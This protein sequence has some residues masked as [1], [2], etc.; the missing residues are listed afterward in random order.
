MGSIYKPTYSR[1]L[2]DTADTFT[3]KGKRFARWMD[4]RGKKHV[5]ELTEAGNRVRMESQTYVAK[6]R[7][8]NATINSGRSCGGGA[9][10]MQRMQNPKPTRRRI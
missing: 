4:R 8:G 9:G 7:D 10:C 2:P 1:P 6:F 5:A 3:R